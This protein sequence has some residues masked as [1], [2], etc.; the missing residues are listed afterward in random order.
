MSDKLEPLSAAE[1]A[2]LLKFAEAGANFF[3]ASYI[4]RALATLEQAQADCAG[5]REA[6]Q[7]IEAEQ[8]YG[9][10]EA[11][12]IDAN[13]RSQSSTLGSEFNNYLVEFS[14]Y[15]ILLADCVD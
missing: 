9:P 13:V 15:L 7:F 14:Y 10:A 11:L 4:K 3:K 2:E 6:L 12:A 1:R 8:E 5:Y